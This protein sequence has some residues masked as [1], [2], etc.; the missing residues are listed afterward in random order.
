MRACAIAAML[1]ALAGCGGSND[2]SGA[3]RAA[4]TNMVAVTAPTP[5]SS[6]SP[7]P[8]PT[9]SPSLAAAGDALSA[10]GWG[11]LRIGMTRAQIVAALGDDTA[12]GSAGGPDPAACDEFRPAR[13]PA[14]MSVMVEDGVLTRISIGRAAKLRTGD[15]LGHGAA[16]IAEPHQYQDPPAR[17]LTV[18]KKGGG[19]GE[20]RDPAARGIRYVVGGG[21]KVETIHAGGPSIRYVEGCL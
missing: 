3:P 19:K 17:Y 9:P 2:D 5:S 1:A 8:A 10:E 7:L 21:R 15:G 18:W 4:E 13:A 14:G 12:P 20:V 11:P 6:P 16:L